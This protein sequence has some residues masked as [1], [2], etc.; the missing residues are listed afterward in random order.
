M[1]HLK[2][3]KIFEEIDIDYA[4]DNKMKQNT[5][6]FVDAAKRY[7]QLLSKESIKLISKNTSSSDESRKLRQEAIKK[8]KDGDKNAY[9]IMQWSGDICQSFQIISP[10]TGQKIVAAPK[11]KHHAKIHCTIA[12]DFISLDV[13]NSPSDATSLYMEKDGEVLYQWKEIEK[14]QGG[15]LKNMAQ[16]L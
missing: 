9:G 6:S 1:K 2:S 10:L 3:F 12:E 11:Y 8:I 13:Y 4:T 15:K 14:F 5:Q 7:E 16:P